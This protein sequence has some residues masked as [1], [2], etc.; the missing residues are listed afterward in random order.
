[1][2]PLELLIVAMVLAIVASVLAGMV[3]SYATEAR[4][5]RAQLAEADAMATEWRNQYVAACAESDAAACEAQVWR[6][7][8]TNEVAQHLETTN[9]LRS[10]LA[11]PARRRPPTGPTC[12]RRC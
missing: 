9:A 1:M 12:D 10:A 3:Y 7:E 4:T 2:T 11:H 8:F 6:A 5:L